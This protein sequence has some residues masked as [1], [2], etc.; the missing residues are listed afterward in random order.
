MVFKLS[1]GETKD[2]GESK[3]SL[4]IIQLLWKMV[5]KKMHVYY[6]SSFWMTVTFRCDV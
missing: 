5:L 1:H 4:E 2:V 3:Q 6:F